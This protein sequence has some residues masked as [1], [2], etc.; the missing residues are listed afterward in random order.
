MTQEQNLTLKNNYIKRIR[1]LA[2]L[3]TGLNDYSNQRLRALVILNKEQ[4]RDT[5]FYNSVQGDM[6]SS[7]AGNGNDLFT[8]SALG[9]LF[10]PQ[11]NPSVSGKVSLAAASVGSICGAGE[12]ADPDYADCKPCQAG[13]YQ[14]GT[15]QDT[16]IPCP[17]GQY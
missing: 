5:S 16:C 14:S 6:V 8:Y 13:T 11:Y 10:D 9:G 15:G 1:E 12:A 2:T 3:Y 17:I 4:N 7:K